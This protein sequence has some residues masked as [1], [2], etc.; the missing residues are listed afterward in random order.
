MSN[1]APHDDLHKTLLLPG[2]ASLACSVGILVPSLAIYIYEVSTK[3]MRGKTLLLLGTGFIGGMFLHAKFSS[4]SDQ[5]GWVWQAFSASVIIAMVTP[6][7]H[8]FPESP[9]WILERKGWEACEACLIV[10]RRKPDVSDELK[11]IR[12]EEAPDDTGGASSFKLIIGMSLMLVSSLSTGVLYSYMS[13]KAWAGS[14]GSPTMVTNGMALQL[15]GSILSFFFIDKLD[16]K[17]VLFGTLIPVSL[18]AGVIGFDGNARFLQETMNGGTY[19]SMLVMLLY[20]FLGLGTSA[21]LWAASIG[22]FTTRGRAV[23]TTFLFTL[24]FAVPMAHTYMVTHESMIANEYLFLYG[25]A[26]CCIVTMVMLVGA[27]TRK[28]GVICTRREAEAEND[29]AR[30]K[31]ADRRSRTTG[32][33]RTRQMNRSRTKSNAGGEYQQFQSPGGPQGHHRAPRGRRQQR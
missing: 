33:G 29:R 8:I 28:N 9:L 15:T 24:L 4:S 2:I 12:E 17:S 30:L 23:S 25:L 22:M 27:G 1:K 5:L 20:F 3:D 6:A 32:T 10:L 14:A 21:A 11:S 18:C 19:Y 31:R 7:A 26:G 13:T 16:H